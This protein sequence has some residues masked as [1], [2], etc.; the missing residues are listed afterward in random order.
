MFRAAVLT[1]LGRLH[2][3]VVCQVSSR[4]LHLSLEMLSTSPTIGKL[5]K[6]CEKVCVIGAGPS[7]MS[8]LCWFANRAKE[9]REVP[10]VVCYEKQSDWGGLWNYTWRTGTD[11]HGEPVHGSMYRYLW[12]NAPKECLELPHYTFQDHFGKPM[13]SY[14]PREVLYEYLTGRWKKENARKWI[15]FN[16]VVRDV[17]YDESKDNF[18]VSVKDLEKDLVM[19]CE[20]FD[21]VVV[22]SGHF[23]V[24][25]MPSFPGIDKFPG[26]VLHSHDFR[27]A[28]EFA[29]K[30]ILL[31]GSSLTAEDIAITC[32]KY[33]VQKIICTYRNVAMG[34][35]WPEQIEER[36]LVQSFDGKTAHFKDGSSAEV[37]VIMM[38][39]GYQHSYPFLREQLRLKS[40]NLFY[41]P[42]L[43][44]GIVWQN[45]GNNKLL[46]CGVQNQCY[47][48]TMFDICGLWA[49]KKIM[50]EVDLP[51]PET[52][53]RDWTSWVEREGSLKDIVGVIDFQTDYVQDLVKDCGED[54]PYNLNVAELFYTW[55]G[56]KG[57]EIL[58]Y[59]DQSFTSQFTG[60]QS[61]IHHTD[62]MHALDDS[63]E[64]FLKQK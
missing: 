11:E 35:E 18:T 23:S 45:G 38:C 16:T 5:T 50:G 56:H 10:E 58:T 17:V 42:G 4:T 46:Y 59:R 21:H 13:S 43:Y 8:V 41:P 48:F 55:A 57:Q 7:G 6:K 31:V 60:V 28:C 61:P 20:Q 14:P 15:K 32:L 9:G 22:A 3:Q 29:G 53:N 36:P 24:P 37:D 26:R 51:D 34:Y 62:Y 2:T 64:T 52:R 1:S 30:T 12:T 27:D 39:T 54:Y 49:V 44:K 47:S 63:M 33:G 19:D 25:I 40:R